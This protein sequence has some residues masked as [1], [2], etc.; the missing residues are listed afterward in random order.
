[1]SEFERAV[2]AVR[3]RVM[4]ELS[5]TAPAVL[6]AH[7][8]HWAKLDG[9]KARLMAEQLLLQI[10]IDAFT[11]R[12]AWTALREIAPEHLPPKPTF[13]GAPSKLGRNEAIVS[14]VFETCVIMAEPD[15][16]LDPTRYRGKKGAGP[17]C[18]EQGGS[19][20]DVVGVALAPLLNPDAVA[21]VIVYTTVENL[22]DKSPS[23]IPH[24]SIFYV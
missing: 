11:N 18:C 4:G 17:F 10:R 9:D 23:Y 6:V 7:Y 15:F 24:P 19:A 3:G 2:A 1:M 12:D 22:W 5:M 14:A 20:C 13:K 21:P 16:K 8:R